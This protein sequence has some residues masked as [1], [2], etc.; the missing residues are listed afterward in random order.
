[1][2]S[3]NETRMTALRYRISNP[4]SFY[5]LLNLRP[6]SPLCFARCRLLA[7][8]YNKQ[9]KI[10]FFLLQNHQGKTRLSKWYVP[11]PMVTTMTSATTGGSM[12]TTTMTTTVTSPEVGKFAS[13]PKFIA[14]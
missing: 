3:N 7:H 9:Q 12:A 1:M 2:F 10:C 4:V 11:P 13:K 5:Y 14:W 8:Y 6:L